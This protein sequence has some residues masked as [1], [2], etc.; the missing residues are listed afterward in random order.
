MTTQLF[1]DLDDL[2]DRTVIVTGAS[3]G[4]GAATARALYA[5]GARPV[6]AARRI[7]RLEPLGAE[8][9]GALCVRVDVTDAEQAEELVGRTLERH[10]RIDGLVNNAGASL[11]DRPIEKLDLGEFRQIL[12]LNVVSVIRLMQLVLPVMHDRGFGRIVNIS[13]GTTRM[14]IP[15]VGGYASSKSTV[16]MLSAVARK[17][18]EG[19]GVT[20]GLVLPS[21]TATEFADGRF[22]N[23]QQHVRPGMV[24][25]SPE[26]VAGFILRALSTGEERI[27]IPHGAEQPE[28]ARVPSA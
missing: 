23:G 11:H 1:E 7:E 18:L 13:S 17:E 20:V 9:G 25:H 3:S 15:G 24:V 12:D 21:I 2:R 26:Y 10:G 14:A 22:L 16:N 28:A 27:D 4:I 19:T 8:L 5:A 6:L